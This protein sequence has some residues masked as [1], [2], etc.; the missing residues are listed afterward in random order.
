VKESE[1]LTWRPVSEK[2]KDGQIVFVM[3]IDG[4]DVAQYM[5]DTFYLRDG[6]TY[7]RMVDN[8][9]RWLPIPKE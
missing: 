8:V 2:P 5:H 6:V 1:Q 7:G 4:W 9:I 3:F